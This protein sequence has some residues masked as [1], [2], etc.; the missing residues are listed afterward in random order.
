MGISR[1]QSPPANVFFPRTCLKTHAFWT[2][3]FRPFS[4]DGA[5]ITRRYKMNNA[6][7]SKQHSNQRFT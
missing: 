3:F 7:T 1:R 4:F 6:F 5:Q 2:A